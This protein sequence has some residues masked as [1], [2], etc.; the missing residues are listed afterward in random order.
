MTRP[1]GWVVSGLTDPIGLAGETVAVG[2]AEVEAE[3]EA[4]GEGEADADALGSA[5]A[6]PGSTR[7]AVTPPSAAPQSIRRM[8]SL[9]GNPG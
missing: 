6:A 8:G 7:S 5:A 3:A 9:A 1:P 2:E 4:E